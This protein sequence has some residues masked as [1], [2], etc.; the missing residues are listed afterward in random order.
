MSLSLKYVLLSVLQSIHQ[1]Q[2]YILVVNKM[3]VEDLYKIITTALRDN[4]QFQSN[5]IHARE[6]LEKCRKLYE[7]DYKCVLLDNSTGQL[8][9]SYPA[10]IIVPIKEIK[11]DKKVDDKKDSKFSEDKFSTILLKGKYAR[12]RNRFPVPVFIVN[13]KNIC[14]SST[15][16]NSCEVYFRKYTD[17]SFFWAN[18]K[19][20]EAD[21]S[22]PSVQYTPNVAEKKENEAEF[23]PMACDEKNGHDQIT[24]ADNN[25]QEWVID[26]MRKSDIQILKLLN[27]EV[28]CD[29]MVENR[30]TKYGMRL[31]SSEK[32]DSLHRYDDFK[33]L[34]TPY[35]GCEFFADYKNNDYNGNGLCFDWSQP[36]IDAKLN[37]PEQIAEQSSVSDW[38]SYKSW[39][40]V[41]LTQNYLKL[42]LSCIQ[43]PEHDGFLV[44]CISGWDRTPLFVSI[45]R[46]SLWADGLIHQSLDSEEMLYLTLVYDWLLFHHQFLDR[47]NKK[48]EIMHFAFEFLRF[49]DGPEFS[50]LKNTDF[51]SA[52]NS[53][54][55]RTP[56]QSEYEQI[57][58]CDNIND[59]QDYQ[60]VNSNYDINL[61]VH[62]KPYVS[63]PLQNNPISSVQNG[64]KSFKNGTNH[65]SKNS[66]ETANHNNGVNNN[67]NGTK[68][69]LKSSNGVSQQSFSYPSLPPCSSNC[70][71]DFDSSLL[72][73]SVSNVCI[74]NSSS[75]ENDCS[76]TEDHI[77]N[78]NEKEKDLKIPMFLSKSC[79]TK[80]TNLNGVNGNHSNRLATSLNA[81]SNLK[82]QPISVPISSSSSRFSKASSAECILES[83]NNNN[84]RSNATRNGTIRN[85]ESVSCASF[86]DRGSYSS[87][88]QMIG[89]SPSSFFAPPVSSSIKKGRESRVRRTSSMASSEP[90]LLNSTLDSQNSN[91]GSVPKPTASV[92]Q[93]ARVSSNSNSEGTASEY[94]ANLQ[95]RKDRLETVR[96]K[97][98]CAYLKALRDVEEAQKNSGGFINMVSQFIGRN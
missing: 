48:E 22:I 97:M 82:S 21:A 88:W 60:K 98:L 33:L 77:N 57:F 34:S 46:I 89:S 62:S 1:K 23:N 71:I 93:A 74:D 32:V 43:N 25:P 9:P 86:T 45:L 50:L 35:P 39:D 76:V 55:Q 72:C 40:L 44:H 65:I 10:E 90:S 94:Q 15:I 56:T 61:N 24:V 53:E 11:L 5:C 31:T 14:R 38:N 58:E 95:R 2:K 49:I 75:I 36:F 6:H 28:I 30:K 27:I 13:S 41:L 96:R 87:S 8:C 59:F 4:S 3:T 83:E 51:N 19:N 85:G 52:N 92:P 63:K 69:E 26:K 91:N 16:S 47:I 17:T 20:K 29:L 66:S 54:G 37:I 12:S 42:M 78:I 84:R 81:T 67:E 73:S 79:D 68:K 18:K 64:S 80:I 7:R 70:E